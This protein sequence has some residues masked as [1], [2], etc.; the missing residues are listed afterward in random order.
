MAF[1]DAYVNP[2]KANTNIM[3]TKSLDILKNNLVTKEMHS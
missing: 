3:K 1:I 2:N